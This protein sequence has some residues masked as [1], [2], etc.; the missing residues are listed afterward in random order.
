M[1]IVTILSASYC[2]EDDVIKKL[3]AETGY[4]ILGHQ[5]IEEAS[6][7][8]NISQNKLLATLN[9]QISFFNNITHERRKNTAYVKHMLTSLVKKDNI[10]YHGPASHLLS[11]DVSHILR[12]CLVAGKEYRIKKAIDSEQ[13]IEKGAQDKIKDDDEKLFKWMEYIL[14]TSPW[15]EKLYDIVIPM[16]KT[17]Q[18][19]AVKLILNSM[20]NE[21]VKSTVESQKVMDNL[22]LA[23]K[24][25]VELAKNGYDTN[26]SNEDGNI[27]IALKTYVVRLGHMK[28]K[29]SKI[30]ETIPGVKSTNVVL[31]PNV[32][33]PSRYD[34]L[35]SPTP[36]FL[37]VDDEKEFVQTLSERLRVRE[38]ESKIAYDGEEAL[39]YLEK[40][41][42]DVMILD[43]K[44]PGIDGMEVLRKVKKERPHVEV[45]ILT[46]HGS[47]KDRALAMELG[48]FAYLEKPVNI[49]VLTKTMKE[50]YSKIEQGKK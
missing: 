18:D 42:P 48:A 11:T 47:E 49:D 34:E 27:T 19:E 24:V 37:L 22:I 45:I 17:T 31:G 2:G 33:V 25:N 32:K 38:F 43:L 10:I 12:V 36:R 26:V 20:Q 13:L 41:E 39:T 30:A 21:S 8:F 35:K 14:D 46:G 29:L 15:D 16:D 28:E 3:A 40:N 5:L 7:R 44:M 50:A 6:K 9:G 23:T 4:E 1:S